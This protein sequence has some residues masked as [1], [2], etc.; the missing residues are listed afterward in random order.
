MRTVEILPPQLA[1]RPPC[2]L[3]GIVVIHPIGRCE[4]GSHGPAP[5]VR[6]EAVIRPI[7]RIVVE[8]VL[9]ELNDYRLK[10]GRFN[11]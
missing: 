11:G 9:L 7:Q 1:H 3:L 5:I 4:R 6:H 10:A 8:E 2:R